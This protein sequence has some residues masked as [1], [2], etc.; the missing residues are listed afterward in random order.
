MNLRLGVNCAVFDDQNRV[1]LS[2]RDDLNIWNL[3]GG[4]LDSGEALADAAAREVREETGVIA[5][6]ERPVNLYYCD[7]FQRMN[8]LYAAWPL[9]GEVLARTVESRANQYFQ[10]QSL[11]RMLSPQQVAAAL[12][13]QRAAPEIL[14][15]SPQ[16]LRRVKRR[17]GL[18]WVQ[19][20]L[21]GMPEPQFPRF[22][23]RT[24]AVIWDSGFRRVLT[25]EGR[26]NRVLPRVRCSGLRAPWAELSERIRQH[27]RVTATFQWVG[28]WQDEGRDTL[29]FVFAAAVPARALPDSAEWSSV[30]NAPLGDRDLAY[31]EQV[32]PDFMQAPVWTLVYEDEIGLDDVLISG[33]AGV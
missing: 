31:V 27:C 25:L 33:G 14:T 10:P 12:S 17:L 1:L 9:G 28:L 26:Q 6:I 8:V 18:R 7:G 4:R 32:K 2:R 22:E 30:L 21:R 5:Q 24:V 15:I 20:L 11:P 19:N 23:V 16:E 13:D 29:E 3:P